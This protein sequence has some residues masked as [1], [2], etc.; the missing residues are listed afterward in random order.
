M[1]VI[2]SRER[3]VKTMP[4]KRFPHNWLS[5]YTD[6]TMSPMASQITSLGIVYSTVYSG[7]DQRKHQSSASLTFVRRIHRGP[8]NSPHKRPV[9]RKMFPFDDVIMYEWNT[10]SNRWI[11]M[12]MSVTRSFD[13]FVHFDLNKMLKTWTRYG[14]KRRIWGGFIHNNVHATSTWTC[15]WVKLTI[16]RSDISRL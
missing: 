15:E 7:A 9:T 1:A 8:V 13:A 5:H 6:V 14:T 3:W 2:L 12:T 16:S 10:R 4:R 11:P